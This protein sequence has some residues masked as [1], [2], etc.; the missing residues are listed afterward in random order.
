MALLTRLVSGSAWVS[1]AVTPRHSAASGRNVRLAGLIP[2]FKHPVSLRSNYSVPLDEDARADQLID[3]A[4]DR[5][6]PESSELYDGRS[7][8]W[9]A[10]LFLE[11]EDGVNDL[12]MSPSAVLGSG[13]R[14]AQTL[15]ESLSSA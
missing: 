5:G 6:A 12:L 10:G 14:H 1:A 15:C 2:Q 4:V 13:G 9:V 7:G 11:V 8:W 3:V